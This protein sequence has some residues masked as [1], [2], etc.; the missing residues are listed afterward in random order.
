MA[1]RPLIKKYICDTIKTFQPGNFQEFCLDFFEVFDPSLHRL[2]IHGGTANGKTKPGNPDLIHTYDDGS[3]VGIEIGT[4]EPYWGRKKSLITNLKPIK[5]VEK[6]ADHPGLSRLILCSSQ[7]IPGNREG[8]ESE[9]V[10]HC[11]KRYSFKVEVWSNANFRDEIY[12]NLQKY[13]KLIKDFWGDLY[14][15]IFVDRSSTT[16]ILADKY[17]SM[18]SLPISYEKIKKIVSDELSNGIGVELD[19]EKDE[20]IR[21]QIIHQAKSHFMFPLITKIGVKR[22]IEWD[23]FD[24]YPKGRFISVL[25]PPKIGKTLLLSQ[26]CN[27]LESDRIK[28]CYFKCPTDKGAAEEFVDDMSRTILSIY[29]S[30]L[31]VSEYLNRKISLLDCIQ[32]RIDDKDLD[33][34]IIVD[35]SENLNTSSLETLNHRMELLI[36]EISPDRMA[37]IFIS[38][39]SLKHDLNIIHNEYRSPAWTNDELGKL[40]V[41][42]GVKTEGNFDDYIKV[43]ASFSGRHPLVSIAMAKKYPTIKGLLYERNKH[44]DLPLVDLTLNSEVKA[45]LFDDLLTDSDDRELVMRAAPLIFSFS[46]EELEHLSREMTPPIR[47]PARLI[48][49]YLFNTIF[50]GDL[51]SRLDISPVFS[52][53]ANEYTNDIY[54]ESVFRCIAA[55]LL[56]PKNKTLNILNVCNGITYSVFSKNNIQAFRWANNVLSFLY[57]RSEE[58]IVVKHIIDR[59]DTLKYLC[60]YKGENEILLYYQFLL[61]LRWGYGYIKDQKS[62]LECIEL[63][64]NA[65]KYK[66]EIE[67]SAVIAHFETAYSMYGFFDYIYIRNDQKAFEILNNLE[68]SHRSTYNY[69]YSQLIKFVTEYIRS[70]KYDEIPVQFYLNLIPTI[71]ISDD[72]NIACLISFCFTLGS[73]THLEDKELKDSLSLISTNHSLNTAFENSIMAQ[74]NQECNKIQNALKNIEEAEKSIFEFGVNSDNSLK[75]LKLLRADIFHNSKQCKKACE[76]YYS[77]EKLFMNQ[78]EFYYYGWCNFKIAQSLEDKDKAINRFESAEDAFRK[79]GYLYD[80]SRAKGELG[81]LYFQ[82]NRISNCLKIFEDMLIEYYIREVEDYGP[83]AMVAISLLNNIEKNKEPITEDEK[84]RPGITQLGFR[85]GV[86]CHILR[87]GKPKAGKATAFWI[88]GKVYS[89]YNMKES[90]IRSYHCTLESN[91]FNITDIHAYVES[92]FYIGKSFKEISQIQLQGLAKLI[93]SMVSEDLIIVFGRSLFVTWG[94][95]KYKS[96]KIDDI[97]YWNA[98]GDC[99]N[100]IS[101][102]EASHEERAY[103]MLALLINNAPLGNDPKFE[104]TYRLCLSNIQPIWGAIPEYVQ[105]RISN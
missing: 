10:S 103:C 91:I 28:I 31:A 13:Q 2:R 7:E 89:K 49:E 79:K 92:A 99:A 23:Y 55:Y 62:A 45:L 60:T 19:K 73:L 4:E 5:D 64:G 22:E 12:N 39:K 17:Y 69:I 51:H 53:V 100:Y 80:S 38:V 48:A 68:F 94:S 86:F 65:L 58:G 71:S 30:P 59:I 46:V 1:E 26:L 102:I 16:A 76:I 83:A 96:I 75:F 18:E 6:C 43:L 25:G 67:S 14:E 33:Y 47:K 98:L 36:S 41:Y 85:R 77:I 95:R 27:D 56:T 81:I 104:E 15:M 61:L 35:N 101:T 11:R 3:V 40:L 42:E 9:I 54:K 52:E 21:A 78:Y 29:C 74:Y 57:N 70:I 32:Q 63:L 44:K 97:Q 93:G 8:I 82:V 90:M 84:I 72:E 88:L 34:A 66:D 50:E 87:E 20:R 24:G 105:T 37:V